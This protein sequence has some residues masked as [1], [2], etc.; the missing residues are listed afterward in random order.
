MIDVQYINNRLIYARFRGQGFNL[1]VIQVYAPTADSND[2]VIEDFYDK[3][4]QVID[5]VDKND[6]LLIMGD[7]NAK[8]GSDQITWR[9]ALGQY[10]YGDCNARG[11]RLLEFCYTNQLCITNTYFQHKL[12]QKW[13]WSHPNGKS[14]NMIDFIIVN[15]RWRNCI[16]DSRSF[17]SAD[18]GSNHQLGMCQLRLK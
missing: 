11:E 14:K 2:S 17:P 5:D 13:T 15:K 3:L 4:Q 8:V 10:G 9:G 12:S 18:P 16:L 1:S 6:V 7:W